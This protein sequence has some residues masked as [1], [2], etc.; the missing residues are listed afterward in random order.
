MQCK[1]E[2]TGIV[3]NMT[4]DLAAK[5]VSGET[6][7]PNPGGSPNLLI[8]RWNYADVGLQVTGQDINWTEASSVPN[9]PVP[10]SFSLN[11]YSGSLH[12]TKAPGG[13][14]PNGQDETFVCEKRQKQF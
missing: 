3:Q 14:W 2:V 12:V 10:W 13:V 5:T 9:D 7:T 4:I 11:R 1:E 8:N 6:F